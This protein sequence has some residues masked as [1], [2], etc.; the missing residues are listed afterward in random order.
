[1]VRPLSRVLLAVSILAAMGCQ[2]GRGGSGGGEEEGDQV[3]GL[4]ITGVALYQGVRVDVMEDGDLLLDDAPV[5]VISGRDA[6]VRVFVE[7]VDPDYDDRTVAA[8]VRLDVDG[9]TETFSGEGF[10]ELASSD[11]DLSSTLN[12]EIPGEFITPGTELVSVTLEEADEDAPQGATGSPEARWSPSGAVALD[13]K[14]TGPDLRII[15]VPIEYNGDGSGRLPDLSDSQLEIYR[16]A[17]Y[18]QYPTKKV[19]L[20]VAD[21]MPINFGIWF[22]GA[23]WGETLEQLYYRREDDGAAFEEYY[24]GLFNPANSFGEFCQ[25]GCVAGLS[26]LASSASAEWARVSIGLGFSGQGSADTMVH[27]IGHAHGREHAP[28]GV[29]DPGFFPHSGGSIGVQGYDLVN[30]ALKNTGNYTDFM[31][32]CDPTWVSDYTYNWL[33]ERIRDVNASAEMVWTADT[34]RF[35]YGAVRVDMDGVASRTFDRTLSF[36]PVGEETAPVELLDADGDVLGTVDAV[37]SRYSH[38]AGGVLLLPEPA[39]DVAAVRLASGQVV[40]W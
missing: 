2:R 37:F 35:T 18:A 1:M 16:A 6:M 26:S 12:V 28:C 31:G 27:E 23:G 32:Y 33:H 21:P 11:N 3:S 10:M 19:E 29:N 7:P 14:D 39:D 4:G 13:A 17:M 22:N 25:G 5:D 36:A 20:V 8:V 30:K 38:L 34:P 24:Y 9:E 40:P 15:L